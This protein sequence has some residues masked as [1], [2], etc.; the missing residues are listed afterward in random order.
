MQSQ[1]KTIHGNKTTELGHLPQKL[2][3]IHMQYYRSNLNLV[4]LDLNEQIPID[5]VFNEAVP[6]LHAENWRILVHPSV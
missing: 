4:L 6:P 5:L 1:S 2:Y 3:P